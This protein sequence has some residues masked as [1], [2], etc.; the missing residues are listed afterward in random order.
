MTEPGRRAK[1]LSVVFW[2]LIGVVLAG[3]AGVL[4][5]FTVVPARVQDQV[6][7]PHVVGTETPEIAARFEALSPSERAQDASLRQA[8]AVSGAAA[9][10][11]ERDGAETT[12]IVQL[13][14]PDPDHVCYSFAVPRAGGPGSVRYDRLP[15]C[16]GS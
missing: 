9:T 11:I 5:L 8:A 14:S 15:S 6:T 1:P 2:V 10:R 13:V 7:Q 4:L 12:V 3:A 16:P